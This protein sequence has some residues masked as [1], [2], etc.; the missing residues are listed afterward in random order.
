[1]ETLKNNRGTVLIY[2]T[3]FL[4]LM[5][6]LTGLAIDVGWMA[7]VRTQSQ[8]AIDSAALSGA[9]AIPDYNFNGT[10]GQIQAR[11][12]A[13]NG[14]ANDPSSNNVMNQDA[15]II[16]S[17][18]SQGGNAE[19]VTYN[20]TTDTITAPVNPAAAN[21]VRVTKGFNT[22]LFF[23]RLL[24]GGDPTTI[25][26]SATAVIRMRPSLPVDLICNPDNSA[27]P[28]PYGSQIILNVTQTPSPKDDS[29]F[30]SYYIQNASASE[31]KNMVQNPNSIPCLTMGDPIEIANGQDNSV[32][33]DIRD[34]FDQNKKPIDL[35]NDPSTPPV[36][37]WPVILPVV[38]TYFNPNQTSP[39]IGFTWISIYEVNTNP[40]KQ[41]K[42]IV[43]GGNP[44]LGWCP[45]HLRR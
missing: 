24:N 33:K 11:V 38:S 26:V 29:S 37:A 12:E 2:V 14:P 1:M 10:T 42:A 35:D 9:A 7:Y 3:V 28:P 40:Q 16:G 36:L 31:F 32:M 44:A 34:A 41:I 22:P 17:Q 30:T 25:N 13:F 8:A 5:T 4:A 23:S 43:G 20:S 21:G 19:V 18:V 6:L 45:P 15:G 27:C 39:V